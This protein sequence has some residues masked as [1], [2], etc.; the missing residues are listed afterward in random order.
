[1]APR[2]VYAAWVVGGWGVGGGR[3]VPGRVDRAG[4]QLA[5]LA[6]DR[7]PAA[8]DPYEEPVPFADLMSGLGA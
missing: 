4:R 2:G 1:V 3:E 7:S 6:A 8:A 5:A